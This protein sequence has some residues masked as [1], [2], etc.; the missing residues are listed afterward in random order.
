MIAAIPL[1]LLALAAL[2][3]ALA[4]VVQTTTGMGFGLTAAPLL[5]VI[6]TR[7]V[8]V[9]IL[10]LGMATAVIAAWKDRRSIRPDEVG[11]ALIGRV[12]GMLAA[13]S[14]LVLLPSREN[15]MILFSVGILIAVGLSLVGIRFALS[16]T[17]LIAMGT[18]SGFMGTITSVGAPPM[19]LIYQDVMA[20]RAR[21]TL[22]AFFSIGAAFSL[23]GL[24]AIGRVSL[25]DFLL[26]AVFAPIMLI[27][28]YFAPRLNAAVARRYRPIVLGLSALAAVN[29]LV[30]AFA[31]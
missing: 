21:A 28:T 9:A 19:A 24:I 25:G 20:E 29:L 17:S 4:V 10:V 31:G 3:V 5:A 6:D 23:L 15:F 14:L 11:I 18:L 12:T 8:P 1:E 7:F 27:S 16:P 2:I 30:R 22:N 26:I 13:I